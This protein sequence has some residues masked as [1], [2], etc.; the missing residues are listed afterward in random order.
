MKVQAQPQANTPSSSSTLNLIHPRLVLNLKAETTNSRNRQ[1][2]GNM[3]RTERPNPRN[4]L[5]SSATAMTSNL[6]RERSTGS[7]RN[8]IFMDYSIALTL[9]NSFANYNRNQGNGVVDSGATCGGGN[10]FF[11]CAGRRHILLLMACLAQ[12]IGE[13]LETLVKTISRRGASRLDVLRG[14]QKLLQVSV[15]QGLR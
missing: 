15:N 10:Q 9:T 4:I 3:H 12:S 8:A 11:A 14:C 7:C 13:P 2:H 6:S 5:H 1:H